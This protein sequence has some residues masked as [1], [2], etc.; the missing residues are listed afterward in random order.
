ML[1]LAGYSHVV[2]LGLCLAKYA[3][4]FGARQVMLPK[5]KLFVASA[6]RIDPFMASAVR[7]Q[8]NL[9]LTAEGWDSASS[10][11]RS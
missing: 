5:D 7:S 4:F 10:W 3:F 9:S 2:V 11:L 6:G 1:Q 8:V